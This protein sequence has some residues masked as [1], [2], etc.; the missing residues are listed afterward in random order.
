MMESILDCVYGNSRQC[1]G[2]PDGLLAI[3][4][5]EEMDFLGRTCYPQLRGVLMTVIAPLS[6]INISIVQ[7]VSS[8]QI[9]LTEG[10]DFAQT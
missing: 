6:I 10:H 1:R 8:V 7:L 3:L 9:A 4:R 5:C 2:S